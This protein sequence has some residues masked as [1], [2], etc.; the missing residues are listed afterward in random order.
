MPRVSL[1]AAPASERK[2]AVP[3]HTRIGSA[4]R[5][6]ASIFAG[7]QRGTYVVSAITTGPESEWP[8]PTGEDG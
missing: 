3:A 6:I 1:P 7:S 8:E 4:A 5:E 2:H